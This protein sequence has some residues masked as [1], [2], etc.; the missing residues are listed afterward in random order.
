M[1]V[2]FFLVRGFLLFAHFGPYFDIHLMGRL[3][4][5]VLFVS[6]EDMQIR[7]VVRHDIGPKIRYFEGDYETPFRGRL[8]GQVVPT[9]TSPQKC[10]FSGL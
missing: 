1:S 9:S 10:L 8:V 3:L 4:K 6:A 5:S 7:E 2:A